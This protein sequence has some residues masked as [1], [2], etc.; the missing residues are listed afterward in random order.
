MVA[1]A[2]F[3]HRDFA[4]VHLVFANNQEIRNTFQLI[5]TNL[6]SDFLVAVVNDSTNIELSQFLSHL[7]RIIVI[8]FRDWKHYCLIWCQ[9]QWEFTTC[10][11]DKY[12]HKT[13]HRTEWCTVNH[14]RTVFLVVSTC[15]YKV[16]T[17]RQVVVHLDCTQLPTTTNSIFH[18]EVEFRTIECSFTKLNFS[19][20]AFIF[21]SFD[22]CS[23]CFFPYF[24]RT[25]IFFFIVR[26]AK[27]NL[28]LEVFKIQRFEDNEDDVHHFHELLFQLIRTAEDVSIVLSKRAHTCQTVQ[29]TTLLITIHSTEFS[30]TQWKVF[31]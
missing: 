12:S 10:M 9:P 2:L 24:V 5:I 17:L 20:Q 30:I 26:V 15:I 3:T 29:L 4:F 11:L 6:T 8:F 16:K 21:A 14:H 18:H 28:S 1:F 31:I 22:N 25:D 23:F 27:R 13:F 7:F 19:F